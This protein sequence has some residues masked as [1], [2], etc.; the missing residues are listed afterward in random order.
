MTVS[1]LSDRQ[2]ATVQSPLDTPDAHERRPDRPPQLPGG[3]RDDHDRDPDQRPPAQGREALHLLVGRRS[4]RRQ[5]EHARPARWQGRGPRRDDERGPPDAARLHD[6]DR[7]LQR[8][9]RQRREAPRRP[10]GRR[11]R[12]GQAGRGEHRQGVR[13]PRQP[14]PRQRPLRREVLD[15]RDDGH[16]PQPRPERED[17]RRAHRAH[18]QRAV[19]L[20]R[21]PPLHPDVRADRHGGRRRALRP[22]PRVD[23]GRR[24]RQA[25]HRPR[26]GRAAGPRDRL[27]GHRQGRHRPR[28][29][30]GPVRAA[31]PRDQGRV[32]VVVRQA[33]QGL[34]QE[35]EHPRRPGHGRQRRDD[36]LREHGRRLRHG[37]GLHPRPEHRARRCSSAST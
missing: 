32:R 31:R 10:L 16:G 15:A 1:Q 20:G 34:P 21:V 28:L 29:P 27:Q 12:G 4:R 25:G 36:G 26:R 33:R 6:H 7:S 18:R 13:R 14:A 5:L 19:R 17:R 30:R 35:P 2:V 23:Q 24:R 11:P 9:L 37:R 8:L 22:R 3:P